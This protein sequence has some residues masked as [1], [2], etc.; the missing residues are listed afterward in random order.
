MLPIWQRNV[1][2]EFGDVVPSAAITIRDVVTGLFPAGGVFS[3]RAGTNAL[4]DGSIFADINGFIQF[5]TAPG[6]IRVTATG[7]PG[8]ATWDFI[9]LPG[10]AAQ[11]N[12]ERLSNSPYC[13]DSGVADAYVLTVD[14]IDAE[15]TAYNDGDP[16][17]FMVTNTPTGAA[18]VKV[19]TGAVVALVKK[20]GTPI[21]SSYFAGGDELEIQYDLANDRFFITKGTAADL[22]SGV[23]PGNV[24]LN[25]IQRYSDKANWPKLSMGIDAAHD[26]DFTDGGTVAADGYVNVTIALTKEFD[27]AFTVGDGGGGLGDGVSLTANQSYHAFHIHR[28]SDDATDIYADTSLVG[29]NVPDGWVVGHILHDFWTDGS[30]N[31]RGFVQLGD[32]IQLTNSTQIVTIIG[33][34][35]T[36][37]QPVQAAPSG[38]KK[39]AALAMGVA[40]TS[41]SLRV[42]VN[43]PD[44]DNL[45]EVLRIDTG[46]TKSNVSADIAT[47]SS[48]EIIYKQDGAGVTAS[49]SMWVNGWY[50]QRA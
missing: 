39:I 43:S 1:V 3:D 16:F 9:V 50:D 15:V 17:R 30:S 5:F 24:T 47:N 18:T 42:N 22:D 29:A 13:T 44:S 31:I 23:K 20:D 2:D 4:T 28:T 27:I 10:T 11:A 46:S 35:P 6:E 12:A 25:D 32:F 48:G 45:T 8:A 41:G 49:F 7:A 33:A 21:T 26:I 19:G 36:S 37:D 40:L 34:T 14:Y 38:A